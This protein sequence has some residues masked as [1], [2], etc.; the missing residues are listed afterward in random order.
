MRRTERGFTLIEIMVVVLIIGVA[1]GG[2]MLSMRTGGTSQ[3][4]EETERFL[5]SARFVSDQA[6][7]NQEIIGLFVEPGSTEGGAMGQWCYEWQRFL[8][9]SWQQASDYLDRHCLPDGLN[10]ELLV[11]GEPYQYDPR[12]TTPTPVLVFYPSGE[13]TPFE[14]AITPTGFANEEEIQRV[15][16]DMTGRIRWRNDEEAQERF[17]QT[18][19]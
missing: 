13:A 17:E 8:D 4:Q 1:I 9:Q 11:E 15:E 14:L 10:L 18:Q 3:L 12:A 16:V 6:T 7:L 19:W 2:V 5:L